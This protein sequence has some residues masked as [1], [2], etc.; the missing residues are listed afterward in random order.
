PEVLFVPSAGGLLAAMGVPACALPPQTRTVV[1]WLSL[2]TEGLSG[3]RVEPP[4]VAPCCPKT[5]QTATVADKVTIQKRFMNP[6]NCSHLYPP[7]GHLTARV[8][9]MYA[10]I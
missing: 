1:R 2:L 6:P 4:V 7:D 3:P 9:D 5:E 8:G 10:A